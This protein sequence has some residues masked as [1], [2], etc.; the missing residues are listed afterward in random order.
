MRS[1][2]HGLETSRRALFVQNTMM[3]T[4]GHNIANASTEGYTRQRVRASATNPLEMPGMYTSTAPGQLGTGVQYDSITRIRDSFL[5]MQFRRENQSLGSWSILDNSIRSI[6]SFLNE[7]SENGLASVMDKFWDSWEVLNRDPS[8]LSARVEV[9]GA[10]TNM[11]DMMKHVGQS[12]TKLED[13]I[14][15]NINVK[16]SEA[17]DIL[18]N[19][20][21]LTDMI[22][23]VEG[24]GD[25]ANDFR[26][27]R[28]LLIDQ[29][30][31]I[32]DV[33]VVEGFNGE[34]TINAAGATVLDDA[35]VTPIT[36]ASVDAAT[37]GQLHGYALSLDE[38]TKMR[39]Q[40]NAMLD[41]MING[42][43][44]V[45]LPAG[46]VASQD[47]VLP[48]GQGTIPA[49]TTL[50]NPTTVTVNGLNGLHQL[51]YT[52]SDPSQTGI[53][54]FT[55]TD[56][57]TNFTIDNIQ[58]NPDIVADTNMIAASGRYEVVNGA[59]TTVKG[60]SVI[61]HALATLRDASFSFP[62]NLTSLSSGKIDDYYRALVGELGTT[63]ANANR[64]VMIQTDMVDNVMMRRQSVSGV[65]LDEEMADM[66][67]FQH[68]YNAAARNM[69]TVDE[70][71]DRVINQMGLV[72]R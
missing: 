39:D 46:Y 43:V 16:V 49:G 11:A 20:A 51:G 40:M 71:L 17:N 28:D 9:I 1:T 26:D 69:T 21:N 64:N 6:E 32:I 63:S 8:L 12:L 57:T 37:A 67:R 59:N 58:V 30:S 14:N 13:D 42:A 19:I 65:S 2:F 3:Q 44:D 45:E 38:V 36:A 10:A 35:G 70:M 54:F 66:I 4:L 72:G 22:K 41:T 18:N 52:L 15:N 50:A 48:N 55:T 61:A 29:L 33:Q 5:D 24:T 47:L 53:P 31:T 7:P 34:I 23:K 68:A 25:N 60:N 27:Q 56:G 62:S